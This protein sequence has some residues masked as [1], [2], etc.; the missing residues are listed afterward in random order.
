MRN[1][2][3][4]LFIVYICS[5]RCTESF[6]HNNKTNTNNNE[7]NRYK[8]SIFEVFSDLRIGIAGIVSD[9]HEDECLRDGCGEIHTEEPPERHM[10][11]SCRHEDDPTDTMREFTDDERPYTVACEVV[12]HLLDTIL[13]DTDIVTPSLDES[14]PVVSDHVVDSIPYEIGDDRDDIGQCEVK[15]SLCCEESA[16]DHDDRSLDDHHRE[17]DEV[18]VGDNP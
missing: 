18:L 3:L 4:N 14:C 15:V 9:E 8:C 16:D 13:G 5:K 7:Y 6:R 12:L 17:E 11:D 1:S 2:S 10:D